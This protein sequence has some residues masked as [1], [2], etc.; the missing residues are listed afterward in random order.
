MRKLKDQTA[1]KNDLAG[2]EHRGLPGGNI[3]LRLVKADL[4]P[5]PLQRRDQRPG[6]PAGRASL[7][8][9]AERLVRRLPGESS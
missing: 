1:A 9:Q 5:A 8:L 7:D 3:P 4:D 6:F 2:I